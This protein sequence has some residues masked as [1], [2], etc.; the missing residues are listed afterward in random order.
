MIMIR[1]SRTRN[2][3]PLAKHK[4]DTGEMHYHFGKLEE[5][6]EFSIGVDELMSRI[7]T[8]DERRSILAKDPLASVYGF[9]MLCKLALKALFGVR[10]CSKINV[11]SATTHLLEVVWIFSAMLRM[12]KVVHLG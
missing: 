5:P 7:P 3:D 1:L 12:L 2:G 8:S 10:A 11:L 9:R 6:Q 4:S